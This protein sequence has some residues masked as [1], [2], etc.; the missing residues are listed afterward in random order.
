MKSDSE[1]LLDME[2][3]GKQNMVTIIILIITVNL[4]TFQSS[5]NV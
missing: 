2:D 4:S 5:S 3:S 1:P